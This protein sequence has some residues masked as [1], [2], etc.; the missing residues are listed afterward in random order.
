M[1]AATHPT[2]ASC[3]SLARQP[4]PRPCS[5]VQAPA[6]FRAVTQ[7]P[8]SQYQV[9]WLVSTKGVVV[10]ACCCC[11]GGGGWWWLVAVVVMVVVVRWQYRDSLVSLHG[12]L[13]LEV[14]LPRQLAVVVARALNLARPVDHLPRVRAQCVCECVIVLCECVMCACVSLSV[15]QPVCLLS[16]CTNP[17]GCSRAR[18]RAFSPSHQSASSTTTAQSPCKQPI[19]PRSTPAYCA[20][21]CVRGCACLI[22]MCTTSTT[23]TTT[24]TTRERAGAPPDLPQPN[25]EC[26]RRGAPTPPSRW[27]PT[28]GISPAPPAHLTGKPST[29]NIVNKNNNNNN[30][31]K[32]QQ[33]TTNDNKNNNNNNNNNKNNKNNRQPPQ[34]RQRPGGP[35]AIVPSSSDVVQRNATERRRSHQSGRTV[36]CERAR[37]RCGDRSMRRQRSQQSAAAPTT[38]KGGAALA[39]SQQQQLLL[40]LLLLVILII[41]V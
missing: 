19:H 22:V 12:R 1:C 34:P 13:V 36:K 10:K 28:H 17:C 39:I 25:A 4:S 16:V 7:S 14:L 18:A 29:P 35:A 24:T 30:N 21:A 9:C 8:S 27:C 32:Q 11:C 2:P 31:N 6:R 37:S 26:A 41:E 38:Q 15:C 23:T 5:S 20:R 40:L 33:Q 3:L